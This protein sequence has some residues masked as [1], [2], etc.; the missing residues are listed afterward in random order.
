MIWK[1][2]TRQLDLSTTRVMGIVNVTPDSFSDGGRYFSPEEA[3]RRAANCAAEGADVVDF[4]GES[5]RPG[6]TPIGWEEEWSR[7]EP[8]ISAYAAKERRPI[9]SVDTYHAETARRAIAAGADAINCVYAPPPDMWALVEETG[10]GLMIPRRPGEE[11]SENER[12]F[13]DHVMID[14]E[15]G[16]GTTREEDIALLGALRRLAMTGKVCVGVSRKRLVKKLV[17]GR[18]TGKNLGGSL[19]AAIW[20]AMNGASLV[21]V[22]DV[23]ETVQAI[24]VATSLAAWTAGGAGAEEATA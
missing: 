19:G 13:A 1:C 10:C 16:F 14:P 4:G 8:V 9:V 6:A 2:A 7:L 5:T 3:R 18:V 21:R 11:P 20:C 15:I 23:A 22:H 12:R 24:K 17:G